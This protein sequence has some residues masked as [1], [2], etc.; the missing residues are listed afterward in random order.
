MR[1]TACAAL[2]VLSTPASAQTD[3]DYGA[4]LGSECVT[5][6][7]V[8]AANAAVPSI[9]GLSVAHFCDV[10]RQYRSKEHENPTMQMIAGRL[11]DDDI[12]ALAAYFGSLE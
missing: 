6:H 7:Q 8:G 10:M 3:L 9:T 4:Y 12:A 11:T 5:C 2:F 1:H